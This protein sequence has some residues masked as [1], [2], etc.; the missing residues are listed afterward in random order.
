MRRTMLS[1]VN[2]VD[3]LG[4]LLVVVVYLTAD[5]QSTSY[6]GIGLPFGVH[7]LILSYPFFSDNCLVV[8]PVGRPH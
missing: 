7:D 6:P 4:S 1:K 5:G 3:F 8:L 2:T